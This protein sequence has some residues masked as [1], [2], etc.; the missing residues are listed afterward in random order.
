MSDNRIS[1]SLSNDSP[2]A[3]TF[4]VDKPFSEKPESP[5]KK[6]ALQRTQIFAGSLLGGALIKNVRCIRQAAIK[7]G[8]S[9]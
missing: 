1:Y 5:Q 9:P 6:F 8:L 3:E 7:S 4:H 2:I